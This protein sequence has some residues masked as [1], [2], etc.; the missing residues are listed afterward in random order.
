MPSALR[1][2]IK[3]RVQGV[4]MRPFVAQL[5]TQLGVVGHVS[6]SALGAE[7]HVEGSP[8]KLEKFQQQLLN[9]IQQGVPRTAHIESLETAATNPQGLDSFTI[10]CSEDE[11]DAAAADAQRITT[12][13]PLDAAICEDCERELTTHQDRR[14]GHPFIS[15]TNCGPR[16]TIIQQ[17]PYERER[18]SMSVFP[19]CECC[20]AEYNQLELELGFRRF[21]AETIACPNCGPELAVTDGDGNRILSSDPVQIA[22]DVLRK[23]QIVAVLG[24]GGFQLLADATSTDAV[25]RLRNRKRRPNKPLAVMALHAHAAE[26]AHWSPVERRTF[27]SPAAPIVIVRRRHDSNLSRLLSPEVPSR[28]DTLGVMRPTTPLHL[29]LL[30][31]LNSP[32]V[33]TSG[34]VEGEPLAYEADPRSQRE[35]ADLCLIHDRVIQRPLDDSVVRQVGDNQMMTLRLARGYA[36]FALPLFPAPTDSRRI[37]S[38]VTLALGGQWK[39]S[40]A[41]HSVSEGHQQALLGPHIGSLDDLATRARYTKQIHEMLTLLGIADIPDM[42]ETRGPP[43]ASWVSDQHP[44]YFTTSLAESWLFAGSPKRNNGWEQVQHHHAHVVAGML[45]DPELNNAQCEVLGVAWDGS[46]YG[47]DGTIWGGE[48]LCATM[49]GFRR[50]ASLRPFP[51]AGGEA[52]IR[53]PWRIA[54]AMLYDSLG[55]RGLSRLPNLRDAQ[56]LLALFHSPQLTPSTTSVGRL[57]DAVAAL[58]LGV[59]HVTFEGEAAMLLESCCASPGDVCA[60]ELSSFKPYDLPLRSPPV[61]GRGADGRQ[62]DQ[63]PQLDWRPLIGDIVQDLSAGVT[64]EII[65]TKFHHCLARALLKVAQTFAPRPI[66]LTGGV[67]QNRTLVEWILAEQPSLAAHQR[68][69]LPGAIPPTMAALLR[70]NSPLLLLVIWFPDFH[71]IDAGH[72]R[73]ESQLPHRSPHLGGRRMCLGIPGKLIRWIQ[74]DP[75]FAKG[76]VE[77]DGV[78]RE[79][80]LSCVPTVKVGEYVI[81]HAG[82]AIAKIDAEE[83]QRAFDL[84]RDQT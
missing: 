26:L 79:C 67:F 22:V 13:I 30:R 47:V 48:F 61:D 54:A 64:P 52:A 66:V 46:G 65:S 63:I 77:F 40:I 50:V 20:G 83:A 14:F 56:P 11:P 6:N 57:F 53:E 28:L 33:C 49:T 19:M 84:L 24:I 17:L 74:H 58:T 35:L 9:S 12:H 71:S 21:H 72:E 45:E 62:S 70:D 42:P 69:K 31:S 51:L 8:W 15:C 60:A 34:N 18:T 80:N 37:A 76:A 3:G 27:D 23:G 75:P 25:Q 59:D 1:I 78:T 82:I 41:I 32:V 36:P 43:A 39:S 16:Y 10:R 68:I 73:V 5:A 29:M 2:I 44:D 4:G 38:R 81:V 7:V 55:D